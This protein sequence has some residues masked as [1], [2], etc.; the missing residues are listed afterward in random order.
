MEKPYIEKVVELIKRSYNP[1]YGDDRICKC[2]HAY[3]RHFDTYEE[4]SDAGCKYCPCGTFEEFV[5]DIE[6]EKE[7][8]RKHLPLTYDHIQECIARNPEWAGQKWENDMYIEAAFMDRA[9]G[10][11]IEELT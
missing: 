11:R 3:Y 8:V 1:N 10:G 2:G 7:Y 6:V 4:M 9:L 5:G